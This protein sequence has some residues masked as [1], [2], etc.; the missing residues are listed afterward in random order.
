M[1]MQK[2]ER[3]LSLDVF[4]GI[5]IAGMILVNN[6]GD[7]AH[8]YPAL[9]H[10]AWNGITP[11]D[12]IFPFFLFMVGVSVAFS[13]SKRKE[14]GDNQTKLLLQIFRRTVILFILGLIS[15]GFPH[16]DLATQRIPGVLQRIA[17][18]YFIASLIF[19][20]ANTKTISYTAGAL[21]LIYW[22]LMTLIPVPGVGYPN[23]QP[24][25][26][27]A[28]WLDRTIIGVNHLWQG[29]RVWDPEGILSTVPSISSALFGVLAGC[30]LKSKTDNAVKVVWMF[31]FGNFA[32]LIAAVWDMWFP[33]NKGIW[34]SSFVMFTS[35]MAL[36]FLGMCYW[37]I[38]V[39]GY[40]WWTKPFVVYGT[41]AITVYF[42]SEIGA[43]LL[44][45]IKVTNPAGKQIS[46]GS[47]LYNSLFTWWLS[48][49]NASLAWSMLYVLF[50]LGI[51]WI[52][53]SKRIFIKV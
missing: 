22:G 34:T 29:T 21:L 5:T 7:W 9:K 24:T 18:C 26:N 6:P 46:L 52:L 48:P 2:S 31:V 1:E 36:L 27:L 45:L 4:R 12:W 3:L 17:V 53:Y 35:G 39:K 13:L 10:S 25:T 19:L 37:L 42:L 47:S 30:W 16:F 38:D 33:I 8:A 49:S 44:D 32:L 23:L 14:R 41:N 50:W 11:T 51:V 40:K 15:Y 43:I 28:A 20:K